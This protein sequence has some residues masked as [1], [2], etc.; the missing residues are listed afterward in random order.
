MLPFENR[1]S[2]IPSEATKNIVSDII[3]IGISYLVEVR[4]DDVSWWHLTVDAIFNQ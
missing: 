2:F 3:E 1:K 4:E